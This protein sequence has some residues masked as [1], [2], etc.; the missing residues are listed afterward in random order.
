MIER[1]KSGCISNHEPVVDHD[2]DHAL[3]VVDPPAVAGHDVEDLGHEPRAGVVAVDRRA[4]TT[5]PTT[6]SSAR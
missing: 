2:V 6:G 3:H 1:P 5:T 4:D